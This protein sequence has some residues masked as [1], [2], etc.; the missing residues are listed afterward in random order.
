MDQGMYDN[1][2]IE[3]SFE[4]KYNQP[5][6]GKTGKNIEKL[7]LRADRSLPVIAQVTP[8]NGRT[9]HSQ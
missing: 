9:G 6:G 4:K 7:Y 5:F 2:I 3:N 1:K 8:I